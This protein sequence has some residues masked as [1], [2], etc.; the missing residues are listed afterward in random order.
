MNFYPF[1]AV[2][3]LYEHIMACTN[4][5]DCEEDIHQLER[6]AD[7]M[8]HTS[9]TIRAEL[10]PFTKTI[11]AL[12]R[13]SRT[14]QDS[15]RSGRPVSPEQQ[16]AGSSVIQQDPNNLN[17]NMYIPYLDPSAFDMI[18]DFPFTTDGDPD[19]LGFVRAM[20]NDF[21]GRNWNENWWDLGGG[22]DSGVD[23]GVGFMPDR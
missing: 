6:V 12:N 19:P 16:P 13:V 22:M 1:C 5:D 20:E 7:V 21:M 23:S 9:K 10:K 8:D 2:F 3:I 18:P 15:R 11:K 4:P 14:M 17:P